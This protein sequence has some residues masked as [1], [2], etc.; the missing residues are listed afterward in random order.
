[1]FGGIGLPASKVG[2]LGADA[3][4]QAPQEVDPEPRAIGTSEPSWPA[5]SWPTLP[6]D[7][8]SGGRDPRDSF[9]RLM[10][11][12]ERMRARQQAWDADR[13]GPAAPSPPS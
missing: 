11:K 7:T 5:N 2:S 1:M 10:A 8:S 4:V 9:D 3:H 13:D 12:N 6:P